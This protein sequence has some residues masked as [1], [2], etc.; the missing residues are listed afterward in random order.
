MDDAAARSDME[1][2]DESA[3]KQEAPDVVSDDGSEPAGLF[4]PVEQ[5]AVEPIVEP[6]EQS[7]DESPA[8][9][10]TEQP[11]AEPVTLTLDELVAGLAV[12][13]DA[14]A[15]AV[16][17]EGGAEVPGTEETSG[18][19][20]TAE[21]DTGDE[22]DAE[23]TAEE[24]ALPRSAVDRLWARIPFWVLGAAW[25]GLVGALTYLLW[26]VATDVF[27]TNPLYTYLVFGG[28][29]LVAAGLVMG[30]TIWILVRSNTKKG[31]R[32]G[33][34]LRVWTRAL[35]WTAIGV[36]LWWAGLIL[37]DL[38]RTGAIR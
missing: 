38:H 23:D 36:V 6:V 20:D 3:P 29:A 14:D 28:T 4:D 32:A 10:E 26:S 30:L 25:V 18:A 13:E 37:L 7:A 34:G 12:P 35:T 21:T 27:V 2:T 17:G 24:A 33:I 22:P 11:A 31:E 9:I 19:E 16:I 5:P 8:D 15:T 1:N